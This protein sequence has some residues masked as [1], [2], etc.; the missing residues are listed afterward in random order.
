MCGAGGFQEV[1]AQ[2]TSWVSNRVSSQVILGFHGALFFNIE[3]MM[4]NSFLMQATITTLGG[5]PAFFSRSANALIV[6][7]HRRACPAKR[8]GHCGDSRH[9]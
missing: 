1:D 4:V 5:L 6:S 7:L 8:F 3:F 9:V 2:S